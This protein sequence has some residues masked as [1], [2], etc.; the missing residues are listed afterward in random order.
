MSPKPI[1]LAREG[2]PSNRVRKI[3]TCQRAKWNR[4]TKQL[5]IR[6]S[7][8]GKPQGTSKIVLKLFA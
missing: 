4:V 5:S 2:G 3:N 7:D 1:S 6:E 8:R